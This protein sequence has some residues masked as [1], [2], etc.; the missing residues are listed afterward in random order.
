VRKLIRYYHFGCDKSEGDMEMIDMEEKDSSNL[1]SMNE[2][3]LAEEVND[4]DSL[5]IDKDESSRKMSNEESG[6]ENFLSTDTS[7]CDRKHISNMSVKPRCTVSSKKLKETAM[8]V[9]N[10]MSN[11]RRNSSKDDNKHYKHMISHYN[12]EKTT[13]KLIHM[14]TPNQ[15][16]LNVS[17]D[18]RIKTDDNGDKSII[19]DKTNLFLYIDLHGH[20]SK[21]GNLVM[22]L[23]MY[24]LTN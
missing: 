16:N 9:R 24:Y 11:D 13:E 7:S 5:S 14:N 8:S 15:Q 12:C 1:M 23:Y 3:V 4:Y 20:A 18:F 6:S 2:N 10:M 21:K 19:E 22:H 17:L